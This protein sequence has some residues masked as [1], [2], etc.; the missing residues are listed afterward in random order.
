MVV[1]YEGAKNELVHMRVF[2]VVCIS[3]F[4]LLIAG[5]ASADQPT[6]CD[7]L[8]GSP[9]DPRRV[10][11]GIGLYGIE[12]AQAIV[13]CEAAL[14][15]DPNNP[16][17]LFNLG[18]AHEA[19]AGVDRQSD[20]M[21]LAGRSYKSA[22]DKGYPAAQVAVAGFYWR[23]NAGFRQD[24]VEAMRVL[25]Q[26]ATSDPAEAKQQR[27]NLFGDTTM[28]ISPL[29]AQLQ[30][31]RKYAAA[32][33]ADALYALGFPARFGEDTLPDAVGVWRKAAARGSGSA[34]IELAELY[35]RG[36]GGLSKDPA[37]AV[38]LIRQAAAGEDP[39][40]RTTAAIIYEH[41]R[42]GVPKDE[43]EAAR[44]LKQ[45]SDEGDRSAP[46]Y[47]GKFYEEGK[48]GLLQDEREAA[49][50]YSRAADQ[51]HEEAVLALAHYMAEGR[52]GYV[53]DKAKAVEYLKRA[54]RWS[55]EAKEELAKMGG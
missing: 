42:L 22:A 55:K 16:R 25:D 7:R 43:K 40:A 51:G 8:A 53:R 47:L 6:E 5:S 24:S 20:E 29:D 26:A 30:L 33:D 18:R 36:R 9:T 21:A 2:R 19:R 17:F 41:G 31:I 35:F 10:G 48:G 46:Y 37:Q 45:A 52:G 28:A 14:T 13:A 23:G 32:G 39:S 49:R 50:L 4:G 34:A 3:F 38:R 11:A 54:A 1:P 12:P 15:A 27:R 44:L